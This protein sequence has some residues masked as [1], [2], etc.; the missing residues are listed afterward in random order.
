[1]KLISENSTLRKTLVNL[2]NKSERIAFAVAWASNGHEVFDC[3]VRNKHKIFSSTVGLHFYQTSPLFI[4]E[5]VSSNDV[6]FIMET[7]GV[8]HPKIYLF[9]YKNVCEILIGSANFT[10]GAMERNSEVVVHLKIDDIKSSV[11]LN[12]I[13]KVLADYFALG[14]VFAKKD[15]DAYA[16]IYKL[17]QP[18]VDRLSSKYGGRGGNI[19]E[20]TIVTMDWD[21]YFKKVKNEKINGGHSLDSR[22]LILDFVK[23]I[24]SKEVPFD[25]LELEE[26][27]VI[28]GL[29]NEKYDF[30][31]WFGSMKG[32]GRFHKAVNENEINISH[33]LD[34]IP[35][36]GDI[37][38]GQY[39]SYI[40]VLQKG[41]PA[42]GLGLST[43][44]RLLAMKRPDIFV[45]IDE[46]NSS[47]ISADFGIKKSHLTK[48][49][50]WVDVYWDEVIERIIDS[51]WWNEPEPSD[52]LQKRVWSFRAAF[53]DAIT[54]NV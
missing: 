20:S 12:D 28:A 52:P 45:C 32:N 16:N 26:R 37:D 29:P 1:M 50:D 44:S 38:R 11:D 3:L 53:L 27:K 34:C 51:R 19:L 2:I 14:K 23:E 47:K 18:V 13:E 48:K 54:Y 5:F 35:R 9:Y 39:L 6:K 4:K 49:E 33:A 43:A 22:L 30:W 17:K 21:D 10:V 40:N 24:F 15:L 41:F 46:S 25:E 7:N 36:V 8:F 31:G 42:G